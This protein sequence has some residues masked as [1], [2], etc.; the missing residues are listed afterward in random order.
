MKMVVANFAYSAG[1][2]RVEKHPR[3]LADLTGDSRDD[4]VGFGDSGVW[5]S[6]NNGDGTF[7][8]PR[9]AVTNFGYSAGGWRVEKHPRFLADLTGDGRAD[10]VGFGDGGVWVSLNNG[11]G[12]FTAPQLVVSDFGY[13]AGGWR[14][15][16]HPR[17]L[18]DLTGDGKADIVGFGDG[19]V[20]VSLNNGDGTF[21]A[22]QL[23]VANFGY[24]A[25]GWRVERHPRLLADL[26]GDGRADIVGFG[27]GGV[28]VS[29]ND[30]KGTFSAPQVVVANF[31]YSAGNWR[32]SRHPR[33]LADLTG[34]GKA[35]ILGFGD[36]GVWVSRNNGDGTFASPTNVLADFGYN[37]GSWRVSRH[38]RFL[39]D[40]TGDGKADIVGF[41]DA[42]VLVSR[43]NGDGTFPAPTRVVANFGYNAGS[44]RV[45]RH[46]RF[47]ADITGDG[48]AD[49]VGFG[50]AG[51]WVSLNKGDGTFQENYVRRD[52]WR[53]QATNPWDPIT[54]AYAN[55][56]KALQ[57]RA[58]T[59][60]TSW[61]YLAAVH[62]RTGPVPPG[63]IWNECQHG[64]WYFLPW[65]R[66]YLYQ[67]E[68]IVRAEVIAQGGPSDW[69][70]PY[71]N[72]NA[73]GQ[74]ALPPAFRQ[75][76]MPDGSP[77][78]LFITQRSPG[79]NTGAQLP[80][81]ATTS[82]TALAATQYSPPPSP[83]FGG[84][85]TP[86]QHFFGAA[87]E[88][89]FTPHN[90][91]H[92]LIGGWM[93]NPNQ[94]ALDPIFWL[95]HANVDRLW[96][97]W[98]AQGGGRA[99][100]PDAQWL[101]AQFTLHDETGAQV[102]MTATDVLD[103]EAQLGYTYEGVVAPLA[104]AF[105]ADE[106]S[107][108]PPPPPPSGPPTPPAGREPELVGASDRAVQLA[109][110]PASVEVQLDRRTVDARSR[111]FA[112]D[113]AEQ[114]ARVY[115]N[116]EDIEADQNPATAYEVFVSLPS[117]SG[118][119]T[120]TPHYVGSVSFFGIEHMK[121]TGRQAGAPPHGFRRTFD[122]TPWVEDLRAQ[123]RWEE[124]RIRVSFRPVTLI[125]PPQAEFSA[126]E[127]AQAQEAQAI[128]VR[129]GRVSVFYE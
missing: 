97:A 112:A 34:D 31:G 52:I 121:R 82:A 48:K 73:P 98:I 83:G 53:L 51:V 90:I 124:D 67:F 68:R 59:D 84:G 118:A 8:A 110:A 44:W 70:L 37:A 45:E 111:E 92:S 61:T 75:P 85:K 14:V 40:L 46:P 91:V 96:S 102:Q 107:P 16:K 119:V 55:A 99:N 125:P 2:W 27:D 80:P 74:A 123:G 9:L 29:L 94:A 88:L 109:G 10:I 115:L 3:F 13:V 6:L 36:G 66:M 89:E 101:T 116:L 113:E 12:T 22:P 50:D 58:T 65:H 23:V 77:N 128:T 129:L 33:L 104:F 86:P 20:S 43:N 28:W 81:S 4:I 71:W 24:S 18:A 105:A 11:D 38:P 49:I 39:A 76:T 103:T 5:I 114:P 41:G 32:V 42:G 93:G 127:E 17:F 106:V 100:P 56:I 126:A 35:D 1:G 54:L 7:A 30:G 60:P 122:I 62:G 64:S 87:G 117:R 15:D 63:A 120:D 95:H 108:P 26:T 78:P 47:P 21:A 57:A 19:G 79:M 69:A 72:Y 25:G